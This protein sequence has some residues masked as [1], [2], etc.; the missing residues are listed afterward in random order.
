MPNF[1]SNIQLTAKEIDEIEDTVHVQ[2]KGDAQDPEKE[3]FVE[4]GIFLIIIFQT[5]RILHPVNIYSRSRD[6]GGATKS[7]RRRK[8]SL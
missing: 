1:F 4:K 3:N 5:S 8:P 2:E 6:R 7:S